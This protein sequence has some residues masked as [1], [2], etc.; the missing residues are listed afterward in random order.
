M[1]GSSRSPCV[2][3]L[4]LL[5]L[6]HVVLLAPLPLQ[7]R[8]LGRHGRRR[9]LESPPLIMLVLP[10]DGGAASP[11][12]NVPVTPPLADDGGVSGG[13]PR[14]TPPSPQPGGS[15]KPL[16][17]DDDV[18][19][20][21]PPITFPRLRTS[22]DPS[23]RRLPAADDAAEEMEAELAGK[24]VKIELCTVL[25]SNCFHE[26]CGST[27]AHVNF[28]AR[29]QNDDQAKK[30]L[31]F[32][33]LKLNPDLL[34][35][36]IQRSAEL[37]LDP[38][39]VGCADDIESMCVV[40]IHNLQGSCFGGCH[41]IDRRIDYVMR[42]NQDYERCH[43][44]SDRIKHP[45]GTEFVAGHDR[46]AYQPHVH[47]SSSSA[48]L[49]LWSSADDDGALARSSPRSP[50]APRSPSS[51]HTSP[52]RHDGD[53]APP[54]WP[55]AA[56]PPFAGHVVGQPGFSPSR[57]ALVPFLPAMEVSSSPCKLLLLLHVVLLA[58]APLLQARPLGRHGRHPQVASPLML[59]SDGEV[60]VGGVG[61]SEGYIPPSPLSPGG[62]ITLAGDDG[63]L[64]RKRPGRP[65]PPSP[66]YPGMPTQTQLADDEGGMSG[67]QWPEA[68]PPPDPN[69]PV[70][71]L[72]DGVSRG[73]EFAPP[74][75][76]G[77]PPG[78]TKVAVALAP[79]IPC[80]GCRPADAPA[81]LRLI[82]D[83]VQYM[84]GGLG[85]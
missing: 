2:C 26:I 59:P 81:F 44:C 65:T 42:R 16:S 62:P 36:R 58:L 46:V 7:A 10:S 41:E 37:S 8:P 38:N 76:A 66:W 79:P 1:E 22:T 3:K 35:K 50:P 73:G 24:N 56:A 83:A 13:R 85:A 21:K 40:S 33:E 63:G 47:A 52:R 4:L 69:T 39:I 45:H 32:A 30:R 72:S 25:L 27:F 49:R 54:R 80:A 31:Y 20:N 53:G 61:R 55:V 77:N 48:A 78:K 9:L 82:R 23:P 19:G 34:T 14:P 57:P 29:A 68:P 12:L 71:L 11:R 75:P 67:R 28:T 43:A 15:T 51:P 84:V 64:L 18:S 60:V 70:G 6:L 74:T 5:L 17:D